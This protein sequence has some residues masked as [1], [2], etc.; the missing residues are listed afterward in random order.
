MNTK[1]LPGNQEVLEQPAN[2][3]APKSKTK[4]Q[5]VPNRK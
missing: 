1:I 5:A 4:K 2:P 3:A